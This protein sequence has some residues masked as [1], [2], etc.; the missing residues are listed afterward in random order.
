MFFW[1]DVH[2]QNQVY[3]QMYAYILVE[4]VKYNI[5]IKKKPFYFFNLM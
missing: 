3:M 2:H 5:L 1:D 4:S